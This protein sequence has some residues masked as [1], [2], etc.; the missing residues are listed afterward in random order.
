MVQM[1]TNSDISV[2]NLIQFGFS[3]EKGSVHTKRTMMLKELMGVFNFVQDAGA[4][5]SAY[6][7]A[8]FN[9][10]C[11][12]KKTVASRKYTAQ[13]LQKLYIL[14]PSCCIFRALRFFWKRDVDGR[15]L[16]AFLCAFARDSI[17]RQTI[18]YIL[19]LSV[20]TVA[21]KNELHAYI[22]RVFQDRFSPIMTASLGRNLLS[23]W[24]QAG[25]LEGRSKKNRKTPEVTPGSVAF[26]LFLGY[27]SG[28]RG[29]ML[30]S[31]RYSNILDCSIDMSINMAENASS[32]GW[33]VF[34]RV[35]NVMEVAFPNLLTSEEMEWVR[36]QS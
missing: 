30:F 21:S 19:D 35:G 34:K 22:D 36:E 23:S 26:S 4:A 2:E 31:S 18:D 5:S 9:E 6:Y 7:D 32:R 16:T 1:M 10:N 28:E 3:F 20:N 25:Y 11:T 12:G 8:V 29:E 33:L 15:K 17:L 13:Y 14:D 24:T 27:L